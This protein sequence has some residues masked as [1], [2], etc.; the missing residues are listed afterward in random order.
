MRLL[1]FF[2]RKSRAE[3]PARRQKGAVMDSSVRT[4]D[5]M[6]GRRKE[7]DKEKERGRERERESREGGRRRISS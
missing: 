6:S 2:Q 7:Q 3:G 1:S 4:T 5:R